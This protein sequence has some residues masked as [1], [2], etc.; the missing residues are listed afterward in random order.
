MPTAGAEGGM[1]A[2]LLQLAPFLLIFVLFYFL[3]IRPQQRRMKEH[4]QMIA[5]IK[6]GDSVVLSNGMV[7]KVTRVEDAEAMVEISQGVNVPVVKTMIAEVRAKGG[8]AKVTDKS[9]ARG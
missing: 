3:M 8:P 1:T 2:M 5:N 6:R 9:A 4:Q 7:G